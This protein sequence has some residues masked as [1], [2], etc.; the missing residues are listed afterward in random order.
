MVHRPTAIPTL[1]ASGTQAR[2]DAAL[3]QLWLQISVMER[4]SKL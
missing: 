4:F 3:Q 1:G 2:Q